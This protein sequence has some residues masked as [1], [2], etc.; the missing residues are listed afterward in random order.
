M[1][2][3]AAPK[4]PSRRARLIALGAA[5]VVVLA[6]CSNAGSGATPGATGTAST[7]AT[8]PP[9]TTGSS[10]VASSSAAGATITVA[11]SGSLGDYITGSN[12]MSLYLFKNDSDDTS[13]CSG[14]CAASWPPYTVPDGTNVTA[15]D[16]VTGTVGTIRR[17]DGSTQVTIN[18]QPLYF[19]S[20]DHAAGDV[21]GQGLNDVWYLV[22]PSGDQVSSGGKGSY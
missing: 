20:G 19:F 5:I 16:G 17:D 8:Q 12:G 9:A 1:T 11:T 22:Q 14:N 2:S 6:A 4:R 15:G 7:G 10:P 3:S 13:T 18:K 21:A